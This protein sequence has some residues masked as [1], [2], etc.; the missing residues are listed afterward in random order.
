MTSSA[1][2]LFWEDSG[3]KMTEEINRRKKQFLCR[4]IEGIGF[5][6]KILKFLQRSFFLLRPK[7][8]KDGI[9][10]SL[11]DKII[12]AFSDRPDLDDFL[13]PHGNAIQYGVR[14]IRT[15]HG[16]TV[17]KRLLH[18]CPEKVCIVEDSTDERSAVE[19]RENKTGILR[20]S[21]V[22]L[23]VIQF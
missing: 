12:H 13:V 8:C 16:R 19:R 20:G 21:A 9:L 11:V 5:K 2:F 7:P 4:R 17:E 1:C 23:G 6:N 15:G 10:F 14:E 18:P 22:E 3:T